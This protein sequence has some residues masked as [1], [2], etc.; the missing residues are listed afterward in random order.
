MKREPKDFA[1]WIAPRASMDGFKG[2]CTGKLAIFLYHVSYF[3]V[4]VSCNMS[5]N[6]G[7]FLILTHACM[8]PSFGFFWILLDWYALPLQDCSLPVDYRHWDALPKNCDM[9][10]SDAKLCP[11]VRQ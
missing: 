6:S 7:M 3:S 9:G 2:K 5:T 10:M 8:R 11:L 4:G 1:I